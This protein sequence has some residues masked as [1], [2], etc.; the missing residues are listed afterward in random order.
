MDLDRLYLLLK[1]RPRDSRW[2]MR[3]VGPGYPEALEALRRQGRP[4]G[5]H[6]E[7]V[8]GQKRP[9]YRAEDQAELFV[10]PDTPSRRR[11]RRP[12]RVRRGAL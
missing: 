3:R 7:D 4:V 5:V 1:Q 6:M 8:E 2:L 10:A 12:R 11:R 9:V